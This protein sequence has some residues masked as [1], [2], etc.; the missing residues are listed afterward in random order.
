[1]LTEIHQV[2]RKKGNQIGSA[3]NFMGCLM[4]TISYSSYTKIQYVTENR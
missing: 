2:M 4:E 1:M 3:N